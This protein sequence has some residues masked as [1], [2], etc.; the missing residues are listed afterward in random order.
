VRRLRPDGSMLR[1]A[2]ALARRPGFV[3]GQAAGL[4]AELARIAAGRSAVAAGKRDR[5]FG[6]PA[7][8][9]N[10]A[11]RRV[12]QAYL[13]AGQSAESLLDGAALSWRDDTRL[14]FLLANL[15]SAAAP[16]NNPLISPA[17]WKE[18]IDT[19]GLSVIRGLRA[20]VSD[21]SAPPRVP[22][23]VPSGA[24]EVG[25]TLAVTPGSVVLADE[26]F[27]LIQY[28]PTM[29]EVYQ[30]PLVIVPPMINK[31]YITDLAPGRSMTEFLVSQGTRCS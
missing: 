1:F 9:S 18:V 27:E 20:L 15:I 21:L 3:A 13:A 14:R 10:P 6:D 16:S 30:Y 7:W 23:I 26:R 17:A 11:L 19:G 31:Y 29:P 8:T 28:R 2:A 5:R 25:K 22:S 4:G 12:L 24:F